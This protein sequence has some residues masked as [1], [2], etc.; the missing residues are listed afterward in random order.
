MSIQHDRFKLKSRIST[1]SLTQEW[2][3]FKDPWDNIEVVVRN[4]KTGHPI[5]LGDEYFVK[6]L[7]KEGIIK[8]DEDDEENPI[9]V[10]DKKKFYDSTNRAQTEHIR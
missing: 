2:W 6:Y 9:T 1:K 3:V 4:W 8:R 7:I 5:T 10:D